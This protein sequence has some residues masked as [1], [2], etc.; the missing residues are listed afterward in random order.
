MRLT[1][2]NDDANAWM[3][4]EDMEDDEESL[5]TDLS[6]AEGAEARYRKHGTKG[7]RPY[8]EFRAERLA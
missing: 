1:N 2:D 3:G 6:I 4:N 7:T 5:V 8:S